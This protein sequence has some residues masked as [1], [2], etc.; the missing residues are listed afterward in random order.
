MGLPELAITATAAAFEGVPAETAAGRYVVSLTAA[1][2]VEF[3]AAVEFLMLP[4]GMAFGDFTALLAGFT[5]GEMA[6][7]EATPASEPMASPVTGGGE[8]GIPAWYY[9]T[10]IAGGPAADAGFTAQAILDLRPGTYAVWPGDPFAPQAPVEMTV[11]GDAAATPGAA[12][13]P[14]ASA[15]ITM[16]E[17]GFSIEG[18]LTP[19][20]QVVK[21]ANVG[22]QPHFALLLSPT[23]S[24]TKEQVGALLE[25]EMTG[26]PTAAAA[27]AIGVSNPDEWGFGAYAGTLSTGAAEWIPVDLVPGTYVLLCFVPDIEAGV[28]HAYLGMYDVVT[29][30]AGG[31]PTG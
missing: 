24:V 22:A 14:A 9:Q 3:G 27:A 16:F 5:E 17:H 30:G 23:G 12:A 1:P 8:P 15:T 13:E 4:A 20:Q 26:T 6:A 19:G 10:Y 11:T 2:D 25:A 29:V 28:P 21:V 7:V 18:Q 31:T